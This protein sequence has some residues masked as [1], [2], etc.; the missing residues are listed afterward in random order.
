[1]QEEEEE[2]LDT[3]SGVSQPVLV[4][5]SYGNMVA[6][7]GTSWLV[8]LASYQPTPQTVCIWTVSRL[9]L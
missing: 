6:S 3:F 2:V 5:L 4:G 7:F 8:N 9:R 1:M